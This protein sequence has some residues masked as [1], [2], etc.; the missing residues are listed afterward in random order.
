MHLR[1]KELQRQ[2]LVITRNIHIHVYTYTY[3]YEFVICKWSLKSRLSCS[4]LLKLP[5]RCSSLSWNYRQ[6]KEM[7]LSS[8]ERFILNLTKM[9]L[10]KLWNDF[11]FTKSLI[12]FYFN[13]QNRGLLTQLYEKRVQNIFKWVCCSTQRKYYLWLSCYL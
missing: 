6:S 12:P 2:Y 10:I 1:I 9:N 13:F 3:I 4:Y 11:L 8:Y 5:N 7:S